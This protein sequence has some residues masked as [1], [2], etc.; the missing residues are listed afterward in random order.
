MGAESWEKDARRAGTGAFEGLAEMLAEKAWKGCQ[1]QGE[2]VAPTQLPS[3][4]RRPSAHEWGLEGPA[5]QI[6]LPRLHCCGRGLRCALP[7]CP[8]CPGA[9]AHSQPRAAHRPAKALAR[10]R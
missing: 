2:Q 6:V 7:T 1:Q 9:P 10:T 3:V 8:P 4:W 5:D